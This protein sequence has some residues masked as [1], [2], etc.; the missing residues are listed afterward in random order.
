MEG[1]TSIPSNASFMA[2]LY[3]DTTLELREELSEYASIRGL[4][5]NRGKILDIL[6]S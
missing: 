1:H 3:D 5:P 6:P 2:M 4:Q